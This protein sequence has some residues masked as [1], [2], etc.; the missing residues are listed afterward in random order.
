[1]VETG[2]RQVWI[3]KELSWLSFNERVLQEAADTSVPVI[4]R[5]RYMG[6]FSNNMDEFYRVR[7]ADVRRLAAFS[8][9]SRQD[10]YKALLEEIQ[11]RVLGL[12]SRFDRIYLDTLR[13]LRRRGIYLVSE[14]QLDEHQ[15]KFAR[16]Y[17]FKHIQPELEPIVLDDAH[18]MPELNDSSIYL[19]IRL[20]FAEHV[21]YA[22]LEVPTGRL[23]RFVKIPSRK[24]KRGKVMMALE[25][26]IRVCL[27][28]VFRGI[29]PLNSVEAYTIKLTR[30]AELELG[31]EVTESFFERMERSLKRRKKADP[32]RFVYDSDMPEDMRDYMARR[33]G[34][35][36]LDSVIPGGRYHNSKDFMGFPNLGPAYLELQPPAPI[37]LAAVEQRDNIFDAIAERDV[38]LYYPYHSFSYVVNFLKTAAIDP[39]VK[40]IAISLYRVA[41]YSH[42]VD[43]LINA[44]ANHKSVTVIV[45]LQARF[46]EE[47]NLALSHR[48]TEGGVNVIFGVPGLKVHGKLILVT[49][50]ENNVLRYYTH[51]GTGNFNEKTAEV[52]TDFSLLT[53]N[54]EIGEEAAKIF[55]FIRYNYRR[56]DLKHLIVSPVNTRQRL[57]DLIDTEI[58]NAKKGRDCGITLKCNN[59]VDPEVIEKLYQAS[60]A[61]VPI[62]LIVRGM[63]SLVPGTPGVSDNIEAISIVDR[64]LEHPR[65]FMFYNR[66]EPRYYISSADLMTRNIDYRVE[67]MCPIYDPEHQA[68][69]QA[70]LDI[71]WSDNV[72]ARTLDAAQSNYLRLPRKKKAKRIRS[73]E[74]IH[75]YL[76]SGRL[77]RL[78]KLDYSPPNGD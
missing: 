40:S 1:M 11:R 13:E 14:K 62:R 15:Q 64:Y 33:L 61:G 3:P 36:R 77:P 2:D 4:Q 38:L 72:K 30:D 25:N 27:H 46:D 50:Q 54:Q 17:F 19:A 16:D 29:F 23:S 73:Q 71:Q 66:G 21:R 18:P 75:R 78:R 39:A 24:G 63:C 26:V 67:V 7:V 68:T 65:V 58:Q 59:L 32:V 22:L 48:L 6:I 60:Q 20:T 10:E 9:P 44:V 69:L 45:E 57:K 74:A 31:E 12:Q 41:S 49:R 51:V 42:V 70:V 5:V 43:A 37:P 55:E 56:P 76:Q 35:G 52:Y 53:Y 47:A 34:I 28:E 8:T